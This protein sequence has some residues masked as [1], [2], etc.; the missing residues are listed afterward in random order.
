MPYP[1]SDL[2]FVGTGHPIGNPDS[3]G[4][5]ISLSLRYDYDDL[6]CREG[7][8]TSIFIPKGFSRTQTYFT[9]NYPDYTS[10]LYKKYGAI[11]WESQLEVNS[12]IPY[13]ITVPLNDQKEVKVIVEGMSANGLL[14]HTEQI[15]SPFE[16]KYSSN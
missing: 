4:P 14:Y 5:F 6:Y 9:P 12:E 10:F 15:C 7:Q 2:R 8:F 3:L 11:W 13:S 16:N 1:A